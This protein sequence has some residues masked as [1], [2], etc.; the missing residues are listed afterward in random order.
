MKNRIGPMLLGLCLLSHSSLGRIQSLPRDDAKLITRAQAFWSS[1]L[2]GEYT[3]AVNLVLPEKRD[4]FLSSRSSPL[5]AARIVGLDL[6]DDPQIGKLRVELQAIVPDAG[7]DR[8]TWT[9]S[10][11]WIWT[12]NNWYLDVGD[13]KL[14]LALGRPMGDANNAAIQKEIDQNLTVPVTDVDVG[15]LISGQRNSIE[16]G[17]DYKGTNPLAVDLAPPVPSFVATTESGFLQP[18]SK[19]FLIVFDT[20]DWSGPFSVP[21]AV[22]FRQGAA[23][24]QKIV[25][26]HGEVFAP[27]TFRQVPAGPLRSGDIVSIF[28]ENHTSESVELSSVSV[29]NKLESVTSADVLPPNT[30]TEFTFRVK[31]G[32]KPNVLSL[33]TKE[34]VSGVRQFY[35]RFQPGP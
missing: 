7:S 24:V 13:P 6:S 12:K 4:L 5:L 2:S 27:L 22:R 25:H 8:T 30:E 29:D 10:Q 28:I 14:L 31:P 11:R 17:V 15:R 3:K 35:F 9:T 33:I 32:E 23:S 1:M 26:L 34:P 18:G 21:L 20:T 19:H 16:V